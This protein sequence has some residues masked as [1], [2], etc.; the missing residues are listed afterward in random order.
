MLC[1]LA[2][3]TPARDAAPAAPRPT[4]TGAIAGTVVTDEQTP[5][6]VRRASVM[7]TAGFALPQST[8]TDDAGRFAFPGLPAGIYTI[9]V[10]KAGFV[11][12]YYQSTRPGRGPGMPIAVA[13]GQRVT[14]IS[15][16]ILHGSAISGVVR[17]SGG[18]PAVGV[19]IQASPIDTINGQRRNVLQNTAL[20][21]TDDR[22]MYR[23]F[24]LAPGDYM[25]SAAGAVLSSF[26]NGIRQVTAAELRWADQGMGPSAAAALGPPPEAGPPLTYSTVYYPGTTDASGAV[27]ITLG[28]NEDR[29]A[30]DFPTPLVPTAKL[31]GVVADADG[32][33]MQ[34][35]Q[36]Q[37]QRKQ[38]AETTNDLLF[39]MIGQSGARTNAE[40]QFTI[41]GITPGGYTLTA[42][43]AP[44]LQA[45]RAGPFR[46]EPR[47]P[48]CPSVCSVAR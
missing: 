18:Q 13:D 14:N 28:P 42:R 41:A 11:T 36:V 16:R 37:V 32:R 24:G 46:R 23:I 3:Q 21:T 10:T 34:G 48:R 30:V 12:S 39:A 27:T 4:G 43:A 1:L 7:L 5:K 19:A 29:G 40:G 20:A 22:G 33:P 15:M 2:P 9:V 38:S 35:A 47:S 8:I 26:G 25:V 17:R 6:P 44:R 31:T 45:P